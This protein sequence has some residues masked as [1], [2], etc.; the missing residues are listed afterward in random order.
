MVLKSSMVRRKREA[1]RG[2][3]EGSVGCNASTLSSVSMKKKEGPKNVRAGSQ[4]QPSSQAP[5]RL[6]SQGPKLKK[7]LLDKMEPEGG[8][9]GNKKKP[10]MESSSGSS[11]SSD[12]S[13]R[14]EIQEMRNAPKASA[15]RIV[16]LATAAVKKKG[17][18]HVVASAGGKTSTV[19]E[20]EECGKNA[21][22]EKRPGG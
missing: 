16:S 7:E 11:S 9:I 21:E 12:F 8:R 18:G 13:Y 14:K 2:G 4:R 22:E 15:G 3:R 19:R 10:W 5:S 1:S 20:L 17:R 6:G